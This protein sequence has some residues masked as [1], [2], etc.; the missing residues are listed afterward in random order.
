[1]GLQDVQ[2]TIGLLVKPEAA[3]GNENTAGRVTGCIPG[4]PADVCGE[5]RPEDLILSVDGTPFKHPE[6]LY[7]MRGGDLGSALGTIV[8]LTVQRNEGQAFECVLVRDGYESVQMTREILSAIDMLKTSVETS[9][10]NDENSSIEA[11][12][13][14]AAEHV[15]KQVVQMGRVRLSSLRRLRSEVGAMC[16][17]IHLQQAFP[18][19]L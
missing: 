9:S 18:L 16:A 13:L 10:A 2:T 11:Q 1:M 15:R 6:G 12:V 7:R 8:R 14:E 5:L 19:A 4:S 17:Q 3:D